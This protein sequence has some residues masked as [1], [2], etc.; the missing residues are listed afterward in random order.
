MKQNKQGKAVTPPPTDDVR[1]TFEVET[2]EEKRTLFRLAKAKDRTLS[3][4][5][6]TILRAAIAEEEK[7]QAV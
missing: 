1:I 2:P 7:A 5:I 6:R 4:Y 3:S